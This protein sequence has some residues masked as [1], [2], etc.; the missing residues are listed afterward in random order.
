MEFLISQM[1]QRRAICYAMRFVSSSSVKW[2]KTDRIN[3]SE[4][5]T[6][7][8]SCF[9]GFAAF[10][11]TVNLIRIIFNEFHFDLL[12]LLLLVLSLTVEE[13]ENPELK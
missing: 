8:K 7:L 2:S 6:F 12:I 13:L 5:K 4:T 1:K 10:S 3:K 9:A 11:F